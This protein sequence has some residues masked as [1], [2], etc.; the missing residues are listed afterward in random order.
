MIDNEDC[1]LDYMAHAIIID[2]SYIESNIK[3]LGLGTKYV[4]KILR[5]KRISL[6][7]VFLMTMTDEGKTSII[8]KETKNEG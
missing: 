7:D 3:S 2:G 6:S 1:E 4:E 5:D 8:L